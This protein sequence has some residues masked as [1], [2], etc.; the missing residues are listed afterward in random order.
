M[1]GICG[2][3]YND[4]TRPVERVLLE[5][6]NE[7]IRHRGPDSD[8][9]YVHGQVGL[10]MRRLA[11]ID[12]VTG[13][14][15]MCNE[16][17][18]IW[19]VFNGEIYNHSELRPQLEARGHLFRSRSDTEAILHLYE[20]HGPACVDHLR[21]MFAFAVWDEKQRRLL[22]AR[23]RMGQKP[24]YYAEHDG[25]L[26]FGSELKCILQYPRF[27]RQI[28]LEAIHHYLTLQ[29]VPD[30]WTGF[31][32]IRKLPPAHR[33]MWQDGRLQLERYWDLAYEP[34][35]TQ[36]APE[37]K[38]RLR[39]TITE[40]VRIRLMSDVPLGA[41]L[42]GGID[43]SIVVGLMAGM[44]EQ[45]V[46]TFSIG[47]KE[48][49]FSELPYAR[50]VAQR[51]GTDHR[52]FILKP[53]ALDVLPR[54]VAHFDE[55]FADP[56]AIPTWYLAEMTREHVT[57][58]LN[59]DG[60]DEAFAGYQRY[61][62]DLVADAYR[63]VP[64]LLRHGALDRLL[65]AL[66]VQADRP[67]ERSPIM[68]LRR[69]PQAADIS[70]SASIVRW[71]GYFD[72]AEKEALYTDDVRQVVNS[73]P[74]AALLKQTFRRALAGNRVDRTL[75]TDIHHYLPGALLPKVDRT[76]MA[77]S[78]EAR[79]P[80]LD[81]QVM[82]LAA[83]LPSVWKVRGRR[84]KWILRDLFANLLPVAVGGRGKMGFSVPLGMWFRGPLYQ[85]AKELLLLPEAQLNRY[86]R[87][88]EVTRLLEVNRRGEADN[89]KQI[90][91]LLNLEM[92]LQQY[93]VGDTSGN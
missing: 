35:W 54:L 83:R 16:D 84:T 67:M 40:A 18:S 78:L 45:P 30:P 71:G 86:L 32:G 25:A 13:D 60:G 58:A 56:A 64:G 1:C 79:S 72:E 47:F 52:E 91:S 74:S 89:G 80:F 37:M 77:H 75:Y 53:D 6:M 39:D 49:A 46:K 69:L 59:G 20:E 93:G 4:S 29:Y 55:P 3:V 5:R 76:T 26:L 88:D 10:A 85:P 68:A 63:L 15:P 23:D 9:F 62:A 51:F 82:E 65:Y 44:M 87:T 14:Q 2:I 90:W 42:S 36:P 70:H 61:Y 43:S 24:L 19:I 12:L 31:A 21:G 7:V 81:H 38:E 33:L 66:P 50:Q 34:K 17:G 8:G 48:D 73:S 92:W 27:P 57:V 22:L 28:D 11:I 41:H